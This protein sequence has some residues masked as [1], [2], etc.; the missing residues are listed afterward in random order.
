MSF[1]GPGMVLSFARGRARHVARELIDLEFRLDVEELTASGALRLQRW[2]RD[3]LRREIGVRVRD[4][5]R[6]A[7]ALHAEDAVRGAIERTCGCYVARLAHADDPDDAPAPEIEWAQ[8]LSDLERSLSSRA[9]RAW[10]SRGERT[11]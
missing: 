10:R 11:G 9:P 6:L 7:H 4:L 8:A 5:A 3:V 1:T 2:E